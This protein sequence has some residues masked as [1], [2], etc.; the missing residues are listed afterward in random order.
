MAAIVNIFKDND[1]TRT[2]KDKRL[3]SFYNCVT[4]AMSNQV[5]ISFVV[6]LKKFILL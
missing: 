6:D 1:V 2:L 4:V 5:Q 3:D